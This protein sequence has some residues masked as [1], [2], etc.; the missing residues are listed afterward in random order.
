MKKL[1]TSV[2]LLMLLAACPWQASAQQVPYLSE[3]ISRYEEF[4]KLYTEKRRAGANLSALEPVRLRGEEAFKRLNVPAMLEAIAEGTALLQG[5]QWD[6]K[7]KFI[8]SLM[9]ETNRL[10]VGSNQDM[11][12]TLVRLF[13][14]NSIKAFGGA[15]TV[16][17][18]V[19]PA[20]DSATGTAA[21]AGAPQPPSKPVVIAE[22][23]AIAET[24][25][26]SNRRL[27]LLDGIYW[28]VA[29]VEAGGQKLAEIR[30]P[31]YA[32]SDFGERV[33]ELAAMIAEI[34]ESTNLRVKALAG[35][36]TT[37]EFQLQRLAPQGEKRGEDEIN[38]F[39]ELDRISAYLSALAKG[40]NPFSNERGELE[41]AYLASDNKLVP[42]RIY[43]P[44]SYDSASLRPLVVMLHGATGD[45]RYYFSRMFDPGVITGEAERRGYILAAP[46][47]RG[48]FGGYTGLGQEDV[49]KVIDA[50]IR[51]YEIDESRI[52]LTGHS[53]GG[54]GTW[55]IAASKPE[56]FA[57]IA[58]VSGGAV[59][60]P[61]ATGM[62]L[63]KIKSVPVLIVHGAKDGI[64][65]PDRSRAMAE[66]AKKAGLKST[67]LEVPDADHIT[68][69]AAT[70]PAVL[71]F[72]DKNKKPVT[73]K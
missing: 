33:A 56:T 43:V 53:M 27:L 1:F 65:L 11:V 46:N 12:V 51:D 2:F 9:L 3:V 37:P 52:Y 34:K 21:T 54:T 45:E 30:R 55:S 31:I 44:K 23:L 60:Q 7:Q 25:T 50:V 8:S 49:F 39:S 28:A 63:E 72:F 24:S 14:S 13:P 18:E 68:I 26:T 42:Y 71:D 4:N 5:K 15:P 35:L 38:P 61:E 59:G 10:V 19:V 36:V 58:P 64:A 29:R 20:L 57:A 40:Q 16:S 67:Y 66:A 22:R 47:G 69:V 73:E 17:F 32:I 70:F 62:L 6:E 48:R 41:R